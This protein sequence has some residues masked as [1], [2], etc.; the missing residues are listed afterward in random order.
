MEKIIYKNDVVR[1]NDKYLITGNNSHRINSCI[2]FFNE[3]T[4]E[5]IWEPL[6]NRTTVAGGAFVAMKLSGLNRRCLDNTPTYDTALNLIEGADNGTYPSISIKDSNGVV[7]GS[8]EDETQRQV[9]GFCL[10]QGGAGLDIS[11]VFEP[12]YCSWIT[13]DNMVPFRFPVQSV[14]N[15]DED[16]YKGKCEIK[17]EDQIRNAYYFKTFSNTP[18]CV[19]N[20]TSAIGTFSDRIS[21]ESVYKNIASADKG[22]TYVELHLKITKDDCRE[23]FIA[24][25]GLEN[26]KINQLSLVTAWTKSVNVTKY[27]N[28]SQMVEGEYEYLQDIRPFSIINFPNEILSDLDKSISCIYTLY[29]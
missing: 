9:I 21:A 29:F 11:D 16:V 17:L 6:H 20:Y 10:G 4:G 2:Q 26:A 15:I 25:K 23:Y 8:Y 1:S 3:E 28:N 12:K 14:D 13:P 27:N 18:E 24:T 7:L 5:Q 22:Q 19:Q